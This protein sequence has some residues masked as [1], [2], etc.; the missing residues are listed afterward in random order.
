MKFGEFDVHRTRIGY[1][2]N[3]LISSIWSQQNCTPNTYL[4]VPIPVEFMESRKYP[5]I[6]GLTGVYFKNKELLIKR[7]VF[8]K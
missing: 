6:L 3:T 7:K 1:K 2:K 4:E 5:K 8:L